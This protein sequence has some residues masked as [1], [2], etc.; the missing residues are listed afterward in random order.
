MVV[1]CLSGESIF[2]NGEIWVSGLMGTV[3]SYVDN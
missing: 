2:V 1:L 3:N